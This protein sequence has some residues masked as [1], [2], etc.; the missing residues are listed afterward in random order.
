MPPTTKKRP[1][2]A[3]GYQPIETEGKLYRVRNKDW[4]D[5]SPVKVWGEN[6][7]YESARALKEKV[8]GTKK[9][10]TARIEEMGAPL[11]SA[12]PTLESVR[13]KGLAAGRTAAA[14]AQ[15]RA[16]QLAARRRQEAAASSTPKPRLPPK[17]PKPVPMDLDDTDLEAPEVPDEEDVGEDDELGAAVAAVETDINEY[18]QKGKDLYERFE[19][20]R[21]GAPGMPWERLAPKDQAAWSFEAAAEQGPHFDAVAR[22]QAAIDES[23]AKGTLAEDPGGTSPGD[24]PTS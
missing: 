11:P 10:R 12:D 24:A 18:E 7:T 21:G 16:T 23:I 2:K 8:T 13:Q 19:A 6:L 4:G 17:V 1:Q 5:G 9:S 14:A 15:Q 20:V 3:K 22:N